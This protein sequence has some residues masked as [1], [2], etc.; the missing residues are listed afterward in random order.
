MSFLCSKLK[1]CNINSKLNINSIEYGNKTIPLFSFQGINTTAKIVSIYDGDTCQCVIIYN[2]QFIRLK[3]RL[4]G[5]D[6][7]EIRIPE[8][9]EKAIKAKQYLEELCSNN[10]YIMFIECLGFDKYGRLLA[11]LFFNKEDFK[12]NKPSINTL[13]IT[14]GHAYEYNGGTKQ[15]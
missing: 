6:T 12:N 9:K 14:S 1:Y 11:N 5:I 8:Q 13:M 4:N 15:S 3:V 10:G 2:K 7:P